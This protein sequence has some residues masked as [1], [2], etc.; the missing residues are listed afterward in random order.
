MGQPILSL[1]Q[2]YVNGV[3]REKKIQLLMKIKKKNRAFCRNLYK[4]L[5]RTK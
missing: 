3:N 1:I 2:I 5:Q 4:I